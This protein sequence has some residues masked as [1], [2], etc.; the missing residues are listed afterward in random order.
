[1]SKNKPKTIADLTINWTFVGYE[2]DSIYDK[3][4]RFENQNKSL[5]KYK[6]KYGEYKFLVNDDH[7][8][9]YGASVLES[10]KSFIEYVNY[11]LSYLI[12][13]PKKLVRFELVEENTFRIH[14]EEIKV[15]KK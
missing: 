5:L 13:L 15:A 14:L 1:M 4:E 12:T 7:F 9:I 2:N 10:L 11:K 8:I 6:I 3:E